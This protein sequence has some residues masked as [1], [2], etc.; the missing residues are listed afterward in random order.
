MGS[1]TQGGGVDE[2][3]VLKGPRVPIFPHEQV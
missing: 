2:E 1:G 3:L